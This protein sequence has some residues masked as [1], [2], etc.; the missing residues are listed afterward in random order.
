MELD[1]LKKAIATAD[2][3]LLAVAETVKKWEEDIAN[4]GKEVEAAVKEVN[5]AKDD[6]KQQKDLLAAQNKEI[7]AKTDRKEKIAKDI[8]EKGL[9]T[10]TLNHSITKSVDEVKDAHRRV[11]SMLE[12][13]EWIHDDRKF[14]GQANTAYDFKATDPA[15]AGRRISKLEGTKE[16]LAKSVNMRAMN[17]LGKAEEQ[18]NDLLKKKKIVENDKAKIMDV[19]GELD[20]KKRQALRQAW[21]QV[22]KDFGSIFSSLLPGATSKLEPPQGQDVLD[23]LE[24]RVAFGGV[25]KESLSELSGGQRS[26]VA[27]SLILSLLLFKPAPLYILDEVDAALDLSHTQNIGQMLKTHFKSSQFIVVSLKDGMFNNA[28]VLFRTKFVDGMSTVSRTTQ[29]QKK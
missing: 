8:V 16:K 20:Q 25:W 28:N 17:M 27:L 24:V 19:I 13:H 6:L 29:V 3:Q 15:E 11:K 2:E 10:Q 4:Q 12:E 1:E 21:D 9:E 22:N 5:E 18:Y 7:K 14:F 23:G 26:L